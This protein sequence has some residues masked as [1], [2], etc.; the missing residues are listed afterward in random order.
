L[1]VW[2]EPHSASS[3]DSSNQRFTIKLT[4]PTS[5]FAICLRFGSKR[6]Q[7]LFWSTG[8]SFWEGSSCGNARQGEYLSLI[9]CSTLHTFLRVA[10]SEERD[11]PAGFKESWAESNNLSDSSCLAGKEIKGAKESAP[12]SAKPGKGRLPRVRVDQERSKPPCL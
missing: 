12:H 7:L 2:F 10:S 11:S 9:R 4:S 1:Q 8:Q 6:T 5:L 3:L